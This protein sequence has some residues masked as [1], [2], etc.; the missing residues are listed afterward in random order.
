[1]S[2][3]GGGEIMIAS[4]AAE[5]IGTF[6]LVFVGGGAICANTLSHGRIGITGIALAYGCA[7][8]VMVYA[9][10]HVSGGHF[11]PAVTLPMM[12]TK[13]IQIAK[14]LKYI[15]AQLLGAAFAGT[16]LG[17]FHGEILGRPPFIGTC[18]LTQ[19]SPLGGIV[20]EAILTFF[21]VTVIWGT[22]VDPRSPKPAA[23]LAIGLAVTMGTLMGAYS[24]GAALNPARAFGPA[25]NADYW[26]NHYVWWIGPLLGGTVGGLLYEK[27]FL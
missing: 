25:L 21:L 3:K 19:T 9:F 27:L 5:F 22:M 14:G 13:R 16:L 1:M 8:M 26:A 24:T 10:G 7:V 12:L 17:E 18:V 6:A 15:A 23:G 11:N 4:Y 20:M 2:G